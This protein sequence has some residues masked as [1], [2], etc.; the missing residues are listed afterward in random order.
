LCTS[1]KRQS[2][3]E[4]FAV[5]RQKRKNIKWTAH[6]QNNTFAS[7]DTQA[8]ASACKRVVFLPMHRLIHEKMNYIVNYLI[9]KFDLC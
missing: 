1:V 8:D 7:S 4:K 9:M 3:N 6:A 5:K 2:D